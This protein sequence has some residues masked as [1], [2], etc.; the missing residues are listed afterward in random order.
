[1]IP[2]KIGTW[3]VHTLVR[4]TTARRTA[5][6]GRELGRYGIEIAALSETRFAEVVEI[7]EVGTGYTFFWS[8][9]KNEG[10]L[11]AGVNKNFLESSQDCQT[12]SMTA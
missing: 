7:K 1:M 2:S 5:F 6:V 10:R 3:N 11:E 4:Q 8:G 12:V 9:R